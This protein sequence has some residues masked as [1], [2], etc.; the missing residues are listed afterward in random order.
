MIVQL[1][2][3][4]TSVDM[5]AEVAVIVLYV[6]RFSGDLTSGMMCVRC[7]LSV[8]L[9]IVMLVVDLVPGITMKVGLIVVLVSVRRLCVFLGADGGPTWTL[10]LL[11]ESLPVSTLR[12]VSVVLWVALPLVGLMVLLR[13]TVIRLVF[14]VSVPVQCLGCEFGMNSM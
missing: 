11:L 2:L 7:L 1:H 13:L 3:L 12:K 4:N 8:V 9:M 5:C 10:Y 14:D 6:S